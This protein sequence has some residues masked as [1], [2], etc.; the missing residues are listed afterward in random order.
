MVET[1]EAEDMRILASF[2]ECL[3]IVILYVP[4]EIC[5]LRI[6]N[7]NTIHSFTHPNLRSSHL[8]YIFR[9][10]QSI[11]HHHPLMWEGKGGK[12]EPRRLVGHK[13]RVTWAQL[14]RGKLASTQRAG[15][16]SISQS[17]MS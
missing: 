5:L 2:Y 8:E 13:V 3:R 1:N 10:F 9:N 17:P 16:Y 12:V 6:F 15:P 14:A 4:S 11:C 7:T